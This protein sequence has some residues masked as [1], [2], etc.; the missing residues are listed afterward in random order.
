M[1]KIRNMSFRKSIVL[2]VAIALLLSFSLS[3][4]IIYWA[5]NVQKNIWSKYTDIEK[6]YENLM[7]LDKYGIDVDIKRTNS[8]EMNE[9]EVFVS[10]LCDFLT[11]WTVLILSLL[12]SLISILL[13]YRNKIKI[14]LKLLT[15]ATEL[16]ALND[17]D[18]TIDYHVT[19]EMGSLCQEFDRMRKQLQI[20][21]KEMWTMIE[22][23]KDLRAAIAHDI[24]S[25]LTVMKGYQEMLIEDISNKDLDRQKITEMLQSGMEQI[26]R[27]HT[28]I[29]TMKE[30]SKLDDLQIKYENINSE[31]FINH[32]KMLLITLCKKRNINWSFKEM[33][34]PNEFMGDF[35]II[36]EVC[37]NLLSNAIRFAKESVK[38]EIEFCQDQL[39]IVVNDDGIGFLEDPSIVTKAYYHSNP[40]DDLNHCGL[41][42]YLCKLYCQ[43][44]GGTLLLGNKETNGAYAKACFRIYQ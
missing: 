40:E 41:G 24:R 18:F 28:F 20:N 14:P 5:E 13:F 36:M 17:L 6:M 16:I 11:T 43:K 42:L 25:P 34:S 4:F 12:F 29:N 19:D 35:Q 23:Q 7:L 31:Q 15:D 9:R 22:Q 30:L 26:E 2:Y 32:I 44:H 33:N 10:E 3:I 39:N 21:N 38:I 1:E 8:F 27:I 37:D